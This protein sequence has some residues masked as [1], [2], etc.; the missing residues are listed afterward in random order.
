MKKPTLEQWEQLYNAASEFKQSE[1]WRWMYDDDNFAVVDP[2][3]GEMAYCSI[4]GNAG[5]LVGVL[6]YTGQQGLL[7]LTELLLGVNDE[8]F[9][10]EQKC[11]AFTY[12]DRD[13]LEKEDREIIKALGLKFR[14]RGEWPQ[15]RDYSPGMYPWFLDAESCSFLTHVIRQALDIAY[16]CRESKEI[17]TDYPYTP[18]LLF[19]VPVKTSSG[20]KW[21]DTYREVRIQKG[22][23][24]L[25]L[26][27]EVLARKLKNCKHS[28]VG[29]EVETF[30]CPVP[31]AEKRGDRPHFS[32]ICLVVENESG[33][34]LG[35]ENFQDLETGGYQCL[36]RI[37]EMIQEG[38]SKPAQIL[39]RK[40]ETYHLLKE[41]CRQ[42]DIPLN[43]VS[44][45]RFLN[46][47][48]EMFLDVID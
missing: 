45:F 17:L 44:E 14:G 20:L 11:L 43:Q 2:D 36:E 42:V 24:S 41:F 1:C 6:A 38:G 7:N 25:A 13:E 5:Q 47:V 12:G 28:A 29:W 32:Q 16:R 4:I 30:Y 40:E 22:H 21:K 19:R 3:T 9:H 39:V 48:K 34:I 37:I 35:Y 10:Y 31:I 26:R 23:L 27:N 15:F 33:F 18:K 46:E 8:D